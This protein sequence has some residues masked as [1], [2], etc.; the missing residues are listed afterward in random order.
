MS[1]VFIV[2]AGS[3]SAY[4][5]AAVF[6]TKDQAEAYKKA[7]PIH[8]HEGWNDVE[9]FELDPQMP[10]EVNQGLALFDVTLNKNG[11]IRYVSGTEILASPLWVKSGKEERFSITTWAKDKDHAI[12]IANEHRIRSLAER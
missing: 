4:R 6:S 2:S 10:D 11:D 7:F 12:K 3:Y 5:I 1:K 9:E 8:E